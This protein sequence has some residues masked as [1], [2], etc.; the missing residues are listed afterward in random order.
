MKIL[1][2]RGR[3]GGSRRGQSGGR[4]QM[5]GSKAAGPGGQ[6]ICLIRTPMVDSLETQSRFP[7]WGS[8][9]RDT[10]TWSSHRPWSQCTS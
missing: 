2:Q 3:R 10:R 1:S 8:W 4:G 6:C 5:G 7:W 9:D